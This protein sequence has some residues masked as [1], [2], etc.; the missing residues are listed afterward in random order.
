MAIQEYKDKSG[1]IRYRVS[2]EVGKK[3]DGKPDRRSKVC[4]TLKEAQKKERE[5]EI[6][7]E[8]LEGRSDRDTFGTYVKEHY[9]PA[10]RK[11]LRETTI[12]GLLKT[13]CCLP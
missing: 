13:I 8:K 6:I 12:R 4:N 7:R 10:K 1:R 9:L 3:L 2:L 11:E 5:F